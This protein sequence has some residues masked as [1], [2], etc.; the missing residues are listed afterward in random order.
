MPSPLKWAREWFH[1]TL[2]IM[3]T[4]NYIVIVCN[5]IRWNWLNSF[6][7]GKVDF[8]PVET[9]QNGHYGY[10][11]AQ[12]FSG[13]HFFAHFRVQSYTS[14]TNITWTNKKKRSSV[15]D[16]KLKKQKP[17]IPM[18]ISPCGVHTSICMYV[19]NS[20]KPLTLV[21]HNFTC[22]IH[23]DLKATIIYA[24]ITFIGIER[25]LSDSLQSSC[26]FGWNKNQ[27][28]KTGNV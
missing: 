20:F 9:S 28:K 16:T 22:I 18:E 12:F 27:M 17:Q 11:S 26:F 8:L 15:G 13:C 2:H 14:V 23:I 24:P 1:S 7:A 19:W 10:E 21:V 25:C 6:E 4:L 5:V 3:D